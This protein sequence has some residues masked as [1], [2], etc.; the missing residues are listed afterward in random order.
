M[1]IDGTSHHCFGSRDVLFVLT[2]IPKT[3][4]TSFKR[5]VIDL[6]VNQDRVF[7]YSGIR[8]FLSNDMQDYDFVD[9]HCEFGIHRLSNRKVIYGV[10]LRE[11]IDHAISLY[12]FIQQSESATYQHPLLKATKEKSL[13]EFMHEYRN[14]Q[15]KV[16]A[17]FPWNRLLPRTSSILL[18]LA[19]MH[20]SKCYQFVGTLDRIVDFEKAVAKSFNWRVQPVYETSKKAALRPKVDELSVVEQ[21][22]L[23]SALSLDIELFEY[24]RSLEK[25]PLVDSDAIVP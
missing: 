9:G 2:H 3:D 20:L 15:T 5:S 8:S 23:R 10:I 4:G 22:G 13:F 17:G 6:N 25:A 21:K 12:H 1:T 14:P 24:A 16:V 18:K 7:K 11:P 19:M